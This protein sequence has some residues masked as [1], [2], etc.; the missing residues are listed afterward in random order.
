MIK[1]SD[2]R[3]G[4]GRLKKTLIETKNKDLSTLNLTKYTTFYRSQWPQ[5]I[6]VANSK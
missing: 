2:T 1:V 6:H 4:K 5:K 3:G